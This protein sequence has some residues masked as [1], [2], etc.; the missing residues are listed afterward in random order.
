MTCLAF[1]LRKKLALRWSV[2][3]F[4]SK[5]GGPGYGDGIKPEQGPPRR[6]KV[7]CYGSEFSSRPTDL[8]V[9][10]NRVR[11]EFSRPGKPTNNTHIESFNGTPRVECV[12]RYW[13]GIL[14][15]A[16]ETTEAWCK[17][18]SERCIH[19]DLGERTPKEFARLRIPNLCTTLPDLLTSG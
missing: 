8:W 5:F 12:D 18:Y 3:G 4:R 6:S 15:E 19:R 1:Q 2:D 14:E 10:Q 16:K 17:E 11:I 7:R 9:Y 13:F